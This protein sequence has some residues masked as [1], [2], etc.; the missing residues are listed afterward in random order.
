LVEAWDSGLYA[1]ELWRSLG[2]ALLWRRRGLVLRVVVVLSLVGV[3]GFVACVL[4]GLLGGVVL[5]RVL[6]G[7]RVVTVRLIVVVVAQEASIS[8]LTRRNWDCSLQ[9]P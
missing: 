5:R 8:A 7:V 4:L 2:L 1:R 9:S 3:L 6:V